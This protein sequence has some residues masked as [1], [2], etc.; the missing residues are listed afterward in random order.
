MK[1]SEQPQNGSTRNFFLLAALCV[2]EDEY[3]CPLL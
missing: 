2:I 1:L 3:F